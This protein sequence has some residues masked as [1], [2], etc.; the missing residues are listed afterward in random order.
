MHSTCSVVEVG[1]QSRPGDAPA[2][3]GARSRNA[4]AAV[5]AP[6]CIAATVSHASKTQASE[7]PIP[8]E[9]PKP[10]H[11]ASKTTLYLSGT[12]P[13]GVWN[14]LGTKVLPKLRSGENLSAG[15]EFSVSVDSS[16]AQNLETEL[17]QVLA[18]L[19]LGDRVRIELR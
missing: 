7:P 8:P 16:L 1:G 5:V 3:A 10:P 9:S 4:P 11:I 13:P 15:L 6:T 19:E 2:A 14:R 17:R 18:D 12:V